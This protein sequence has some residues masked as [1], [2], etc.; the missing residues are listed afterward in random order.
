[1]IINLTKAADKAYQKLP[2]NIQKKTDKQFVLV[3]IDYGIK[4]GGRTLCP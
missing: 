4:P 2:L 1:M 3:S